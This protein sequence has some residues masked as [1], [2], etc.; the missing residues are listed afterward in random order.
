[1]AAVTRV[2]SLVWTGRRT[3]SDC[4]FDPVKFVQDFDNAGCANHH[5]HVDAHGLQGSPSSRAAAA[6]P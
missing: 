1:M 5:M 4:T 2:R 6:A 3:I